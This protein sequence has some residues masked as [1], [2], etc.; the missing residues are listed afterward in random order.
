MATI[1]RPGDDRDW[2]E[3]FPEVIDDETRRKYLNSALMLMAAHMTRGN[4]SAKVAARRIH[5]F[6]WKDNVA[7]PSKDDIESFGW[8]SWYVFKI[9]ET[10]PVASRS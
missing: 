9:V 3:H 8:I 7:Y 2:H 10:E 5:E 6:W 4:A 1:I